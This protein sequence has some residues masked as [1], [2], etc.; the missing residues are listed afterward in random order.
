[1]LSQGAAIA[2]PAYPVIDATVAPFAHLDVLSRSEVAQLLDSSARG[3]YPVLRRCALAVLNSGGFL[4]DS[5]ELLQRYPD[6]D[7]SL[8][9]TERGIQLALR[10]APA[11]AFV[12]G[13]IIRG[14]GEHLFSVLRDIVYVANEI[15]GNPHF[16][17]RSST[18]ITDTVF[19]ILRNANVLRGDEQP[20]LVVCWGGHTIARHEY[21]YTK[22]VG[23]ELGLRGLDICTGCGPGAMKGPM[24]GAAIGH[25]KQRI[26][27]GRYLGL[28]E[29]GIIAAESPNPIVNSLVI[30]PDIEKRLEAFMRVGHAFVI[31]PGGVGSMEELLYLLGLL[32]HPGNRELPLPLILTGPAECRDYF[33]QIDAFISS[34]LGAAARNRYRIIV[35]DAPEVARA[36]VAGLRQVR[37]FRAKSGDAYYFNWLLRISE[38]FQSPFEPTHENMAALQL[39]PDASP[40][41]LAADL[42]R[43]FSGIVAGNLK[44]PAMRAVEQ[45]GPFELRGE[46]SLMRSIDEILTCFVEQ[47]RMKL[48]GKKYVPCYRLV[49]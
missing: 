33:L 26:R 30:L 19:H 45:R 36:V 44:E 43:V 12:D 15:R 4:D 31:F 21:D 18:G 38:S 10:N 24:K 8:A 2:Q 9:P 20:D 17:L 40:E 48:P 11:V 37:E 32:Q 27:S 34:T 23:Y 46:P 1:V 7:L 28:T 6:F 47:Q 3:L 29:P 13:K 5:R 39:R 25:A 41:L 16:D 22:L 14:I 42:R 49:R 35:D